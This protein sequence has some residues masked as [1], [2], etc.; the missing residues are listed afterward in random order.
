MAPVERIADALA[1]ARHSGNALCS[2]DYD[3]WE[4]DRKAARA[5]LEAIK[6]PTRAMI[7]AGFVARDMERSLVAIWQ[8]MIDAALAE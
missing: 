6:K 1:N 5:L 7:D 4:S 2:I 3:I 8:A